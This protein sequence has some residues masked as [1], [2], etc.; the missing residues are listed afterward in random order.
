MT[1][2]FRFVD[3]R[4]IYRWYILI[5]TCAGNCDWLFHW[6]WEIMYSC[7]I[8]FA[9]FYDF[10]IGFWNYSDRVVLFVLT[11]W[12]YLFWQS[13]IICSDRVVFFVLTEWYYL[14]WQATRIHDLPL[15]WLGP[16][17]SIN[18]GGVI[19]ALWAQ[20]F[21]AVHI[22]MQQ[23]FRYKTVLTEWYFLFWQSGTICSDRV[24]L[25]VL[26]EWYF[27]FWQCPGLDQG[28]Q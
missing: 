19:L 8:V 18:S 16:G 3:K 2:L 21:I 20:T 14:F 1:S 10:G 27:L 23:Y 6:Q 26:T 13:G 4:A 11:E 25:F 9:S 7:G 24:V 15:S 22:L 5:H 28:L 12:Y 17:T